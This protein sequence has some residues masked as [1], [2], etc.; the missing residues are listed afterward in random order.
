MTG[1][2]ILVEGPEATGKSTLCRLLS[3]RTPGSVVFHCPKGDSKVSNELYDVVKDN[4]DMDERVKRLVL[5][6]THVENINHLNKLRQDGHTVFCDR[7][8]V[9]FL[10]YQGVSDN[11]I[12]KMIEVHHVPSLEC[13]AAIILMADKPVMIQRLTERG[14][15]S[16]DSYFLANIERIMDRY[17]ELAANPFADVISIDTSDIDQ[18][19]CLEIAVNILKERF[20]NEW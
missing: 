7:S 20:G 14:V 8:I 9:S 13:D 16:L 19:E 12:L 10:T 11:D 3:E 1:K 4:S 18:D 2:I 17:R 6:A 15:D 5:L